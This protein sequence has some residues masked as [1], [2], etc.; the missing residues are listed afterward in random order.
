[1]S[2]ATVSILIMS[3]A[4]LYVAVRRRARRKETAEKSEDQRE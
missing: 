4:V 1:M 3:V 2:S